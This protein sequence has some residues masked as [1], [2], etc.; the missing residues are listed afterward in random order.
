[1]SQMLSITASGKSQQQSTQGVAT[2][3][4]EPILLLARSRGN[5]ARTATLISSLPSYAVTQRQQVSA[6]AVIDSLGRQLTPPNGSK[7]SVKA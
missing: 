3:L 6:Y 5:Q 4:R 7:I 1:M 2:S